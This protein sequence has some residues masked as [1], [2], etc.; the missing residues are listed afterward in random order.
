MRLNWNQDFYLRRSEL[1]VGTFTTCTH[2]IQVFCNVVDFP[3]YNYPAR[4][5]S[6]MVFDLFHSV[7]QQCSSRH[8]VT[9]SILTSVVASLNA[10]DQLASPTNLSN[11]LLLLVNALGPPFY[12][13]KL[14]TALNVVDINRRM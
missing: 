2:L 3:V 5:S 7:R 12:S 1:I 13:L 14:H 9:V 6:L 11:E 8:I 4:F 10:K